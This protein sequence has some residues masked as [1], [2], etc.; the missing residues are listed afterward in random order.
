MQGRDLHTALK[1]TVIRQGRVG[2]MEAAL[3]QLQWG[4]DEKGYGLHVAPNSFSASGLQSTD[5]LAYL[6]F[7]RFDRCSFT[8][9]KRCFARWASEDFDVDAFGRAFNECF[10]NLQTA[11]R[12]LNSCGFQLPQPEGW[13]YFFGRSR[14]PTS[15]QTG[16][17]GDGHSAHSVNTMKASEDSGFDFRF[18]FIDTMQGKGFVTHY[19]PKHL[20]VSSEVDGVLKFLGL[21]QFAECPEFDFAGCYFRTQSF[22]PEEDN[23]WNTSVEYVHRSFDAHKEHF[24][25]AIESLLKASAAMESV[26]MTLLPLRQSSDRMKADIATNVRKPSIVRMVKT[27]ASAA[28]SRLPDNFDVALS[29]AG[30][31]RE[32]AHALAEI[33]RREGFAV[34]YDDFY[35]EQLWGK[36][37]TTFFDEIFRKRARFCVI[38]VSQEYQ[39]SKWTLT[40]QEVRKPGHWRR[41]ATTIFC[42]FELTT[43]N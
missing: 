34:F 8:A 12:S 13:G 37:L 21:N 4:K 26:G 2:T 17:D 30:T 38:F 10:G 18:T 24:S 39:A 40:N 29:F 32:H 20:P 42:R 5:L 36:N 15:R 31:E 27:A 35:P 14:S 16:M 6:G 25:T 22:Q 3:V 41:K 33:L 7:Q 28:D 9:P 11:Q 23:P 1:S 43:R 19:R